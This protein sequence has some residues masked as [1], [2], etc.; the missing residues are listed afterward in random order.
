MERQGYLAVPSDDLRM[1]GAPELLAPTTD[2]L[3]P[4]LG[5]CFPAKGPSDYTM[6][7]LKFKTDSHFR[8]DTCLLELAC[9]QLLPCFGP[10]LTSSVKEAR[11]SADFV[12]DFQ[13]EVVDGLCVRGNL[14]GQAIY[15]GNCPED[16]GL[17]S[18]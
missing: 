4:K 18:R 1:V 2:I 11:S 9:M 14:Q 10:T 15:W 16:C 17:G 3:P 5:A 8:N 7:R 6:T 13:Q 12:D